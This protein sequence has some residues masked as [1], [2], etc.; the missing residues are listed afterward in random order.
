[1][2]GGIDYQR[3]SRGDGAAFSRWFLPAPGESAKPKN[4][5]KKTSTHDSR[6]HIPAF[7]I[8]EGVHVHY[9]LAQP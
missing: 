6:I 4:N 8:L 7:P 1:M 9:P 3:A 2:R 5:Y